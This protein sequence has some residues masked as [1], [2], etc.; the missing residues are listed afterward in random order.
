MCEAVSH[1]PKQGAPS[2][3]FQS[4]AGWLDEWG[5]LIQGA[6]AVRRSGEQ[7]SIELSDRAPF[8]TLSH[9]PAVGPVGSQDIPTPKSVL[10]R[11]CE[12]SLGHYAALRELL[13]IKRCALPP[14]TPLHR[15]EV[16]ATASG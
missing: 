6:G 13:G 1:S 4:E 5:Q 16:G 8:L 9:T 3:T 15:K 7:N 2:R 14:G 12:G 11:R 10:Q